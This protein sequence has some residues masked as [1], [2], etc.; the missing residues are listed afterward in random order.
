MVTALS[1]RT[2]AGE[3]CDLKLIEAPHALMPGGSLTT[4][5]GPS[6]SWE[7]ALPAIADGS[8][9]PAMGLFKCVRL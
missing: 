6:M 9:L 4:G 7:V 8:G 1:E 2:N 3:V 5:F